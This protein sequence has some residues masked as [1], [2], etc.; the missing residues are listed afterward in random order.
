MAKT[1]ELQ[2]VTDL[3]KIAKLTVDGPAEPIN[4]AAVKHAMEAIIASNAFYSNY[5]SLVS[6]SGARVVERNVTDYEIV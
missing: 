1:L 5:G 3:G 4:A 2:F 6:V